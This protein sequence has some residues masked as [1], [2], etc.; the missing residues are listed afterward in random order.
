MAWAVALHVV[1][2]F[3]LMVP[4][5]VLALLPFYIFVNPLELTSIVSIFHEIA[6]AIAL[7]FGVWFVA[8]WRFR[9]DFRG[10]FNKRRLMLFT[11]VVWLT[12][13]AL[14]ISLYTILNWTVLMG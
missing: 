14:G 3:A 7:G 5:F 9:R 12:A 11:M 10:C 4:S 2:V 6:G 8:A 13:L 1:M